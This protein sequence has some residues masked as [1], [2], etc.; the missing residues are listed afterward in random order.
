MAVKF[1]GK[2]VREDFVPDFKF[3]DYRKLV[4]GQSEIYW[5]CEYRPRYAQL[6]DAS[7]SGPEI[8]FCW[9]PS[10]YTLPSLRSW[11]AS[12]YEHA[13]SGSFGWAWLLFFGLSYLACSK[14]V[15]SSLLTA[16]FIISQW[17]FTRSH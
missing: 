2:Q 16:S 6:S 15:K 5:S 14:V 13:M 17:T 3:T 7:L 1:L 10:F 9:R 4:V 11:C 8:F 12:I